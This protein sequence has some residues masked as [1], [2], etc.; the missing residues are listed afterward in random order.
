MLVHSKIEIQYIPYIIIIQRK[1]NMH[2]YLN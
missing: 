1:E 2:S